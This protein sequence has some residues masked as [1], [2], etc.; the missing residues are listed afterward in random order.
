MVWADICCSLLPT[1]SAKAAEQAL[2]R[3][4][5]KVW[6]SEDALSDDENLRGD[7]RALKLNSW[8]TKRVFWVPVL[9]RG[10]LHV[11]QLP[12]D[13]PG[14]RPEGAEAFVKAVRAA[15]NMRFS[16]SRAATR[17]LH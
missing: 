17:A 7:V 16:G 11:S 5:N 9:C 6:C 10:K 12:D 13:F 15:L 1:T 8:D 14:D 2:A 3:K 4:G